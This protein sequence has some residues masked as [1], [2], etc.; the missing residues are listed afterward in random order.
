MPYTVANAKD[1]VKELVIK[2]G[3]LI[4]TQPA[5]EGVLSLLREIFN[6]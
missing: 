6:D 5:G 3:G 4:A 1:V 2:K